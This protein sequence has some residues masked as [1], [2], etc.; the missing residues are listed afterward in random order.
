MKIK[1]VVIILIQCIVVV[2]VEGVKSIIIYN[3]CD[4]VP[5]TQAFIKSHNII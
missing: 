4:Y 3:I 1:Y 2:L 5:L